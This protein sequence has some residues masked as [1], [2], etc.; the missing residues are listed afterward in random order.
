MPPSKS[1]SRAKKRSPLAFEDLMSV[2][3]VSGP[4][5]SPDGR[6]VAY[7]ITRADLD[8]NK[9]GST[10]R[11][12]DLGT[13]ESRDLTPG[14]GSH[15]SPAWSPDSTHLAFVSDRGDEGAQ[16][17]V[18]PMDGGEARQVTS[19]KG[20]AG[21]PVWSPDGTRIA[22]ARSVAVSPH[23]KGAQ[24]DPTHQ[25]V[26]GLPNE[27][28][29]ARVE[30]SLLFRHWDQWRDMRRSNL[31]IV[32]LASGE[33]EDLTPGDADV[34][35]ISLGGAQDFVFSPKGD[36]IAYVKNP[37]RVVARSTNNSIFV[38]GLAGIR[39]KGRAVKVSDTRACDS[40]PVYSPDGRYLGYLG[41]AKVGYEADR[42]RI[43]LYD[44]RTR[45]TR[46]LTEDLDRSA[47][48]LEFS[49]D[50]GSVYFLAQDRAH[51]SVY[52]VSVDKGNVVQ[53]TEGTTNSSLA[54]IPGS[55]DL[56]VGREST[57]RPVELY[58]LT[59][60]RGIRPIL[61][62]GP[63][64][65][66]VPKDAGAKVEQMTHHN[67]HLGKQVELHDIEEFWYEGA[68]GDPVHGWLVKPPGFTAKRRWPV[69]LIIHGGPQS[70]FLDHFNYRWSVQMFAAQ[71]FVAVQL[72]P[73]GSSGYGDTFQ[74]QISGDWG[75]RCYDD[76][77]AGIDHFL[78]RYRYLDGDRMVAAGASF[79]GFMVNWIAG[80]DH[81]FKAIVSHDGIFNAETMAY[82]TEELW[83][84]EWEHGGL[85][86]TNR[87]KFLEF[88][89]HLH[90]GAFRTP[91]LVVQ[92][93]Q[94]FRCPAS[95]G[96]SLF[97]ALQTLGVESKFL[98]FPDEGHW[99]LKPANSQVWYANVLG[100]LRDHV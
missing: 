99:V 91:M 47:A 56:L 66:G 9:M 65:K 100:W 57:T 85:P 52:R 96:L 67:D 19:G 21:T 70:A 72:N 26:Y 49:A 4:K 82:S 42:R 23:L 6:L 81:R 75:G 84:E 25:E 69:A 36:E 89:P 74:D 40:E 97:T 59:L 24:A 45:R 62:N 78:S 94:D 92:G 61:E 50:G 31:F 76:I 71:G 27:H 87:E 77:M 20:G 53:L 48:T 39:R 2:E 98:W 16:V 38:Q 79:G 12:L 34:P 51:V 7:T 64:A 41:C 58:R 14:P 18:L 54:I 11:L 86:H 28:S 33:M 80:H 95:E 55:R 15:S 17:W 73:R 37:D 83:F 43:K 35:P 90:A 8:E 32:D 68:D 44:R 60:G 88:S 29:K 1:R 30:T 5:V 3:R 63:A 10:V 93:E 13:G 46:S 22:L